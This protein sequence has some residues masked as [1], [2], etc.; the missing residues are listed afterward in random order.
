[1][2]WTTI[3]PTATDPDA[4]LTAFLAKA[5]TDNPAAIANGDAGAPRIQDA[6]L[7]TTVTAAGRTWVAAR[8]AGTSWNA[9]GSIVTAVITQ[10][11]PPVSGVVSP[12]E[13]V[14]GSALRAS[15]ASGSTGATLPGNWECMGFISA[16]NSASG[17]ERTTT[18][19]RVS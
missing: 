5:W 16:R 2:A 3:P 15:N 10:A 11:G 14:E 6:A 18:W 7:G 12:G 17:A 8:Y 4:P 1:M 19:R 9:V 13:V